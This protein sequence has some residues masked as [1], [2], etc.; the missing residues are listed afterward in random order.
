LGMLLGIISGA[1]LFA[2]LLFVAFIRRFLFICRPNQILIFSGRKQVINGREVGYRVLHGGRSYRRPMIETVAAMDVSLISVPMQVHGAY[3]KGGIPL[4]VNAVANI[5]IS[6]HPQLVGNAIERFLGR[7]RLE[8]ARVA[9]ETLEAHVRGVL[10]QLTPEQINHDRL[11]FAN[12]L[13]K[14]VKND[15]DKLGLQLDTLKIQHVADDRNYLE[16]IGRA[17]IAEILRDAEIA[18][19]NAV[20]AAEEA[21]AAAHARGEV[22][23]LNATAAIQAKE[24]ELRQIRADLEAQA[25]SEEERTEAAALEARAQAEQELQRIRGEL[26]QLR[27]AA[28][29]TIPAQV[30]RKVRELVAA[31]K[32]STI[33]AN[34]EAQAQ[35]LAAVADA[36]RETAGRAMEMFVLQHLDEI[37]AQ[38]AQAAGR[39]SV[40][41]VN[42]VDAGDGKTMPAYVASYPA[43]VGALL[44]QVARTLGI[45]LPKL[46]SGSGNG[47]SAERRPA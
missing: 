44:D 13:E 37:V 45:D 27:L 41:H 46:L 35:A 9:K 11:E 47:V 4:S 36:W 43:A 5:K 31:G 28:E 17:I 3:S 23:K 15:L 34:G 10:A 30:E 29:V 2:F 1:T 32:A 7:D 40:G 22:A 39:L 24:N 25:K 12:Q 21:E 16:S 18:E 42:L 33:S 6:T 38:V 8:I 26:E 19:S 14:D 20:R